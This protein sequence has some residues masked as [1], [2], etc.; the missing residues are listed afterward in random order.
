MTAPM[1]DIADDA[2]I[3]AVR[4]RE[5]G[6]SDWSGLQ[7]WL[8]A[9]ASHLEAYDAVIDADEWL[10]RTWSVSRSEIAASKPAGSVSILREPAPIVER[11]KLLRFALP[12]A[13][14]AALV[15]VATWSV[16]PTGPTP[17]EYVTQ[18]GEH[19]SFALADGSRIEI[20]GASRLTY[21]A[22]KPRMI[23]LESGEAVFKVR[24][25]ATKPFVVQA[26]DARLIDAGTE[27]NV[28]HE[29]GR[30]EV[31]VAEGAVI[32]DGGAAPIRLEPGEWLR[33][34]G[35]GATIETGTTNLGSVGSWR[36]GL[37]QYDDA[38]LA[39]IAQDLSRS[40]GAAVRPSRAVGNLRY[41]GT[42]A[43]D[44]PA[45]DVLTRIG[46]LLGVTFRADGDGW[47]MT[48]RDAAIR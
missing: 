30:L 10:D 16:L 4:V 18:P 19:R 9:D 44:G 35:F 8:E 23:S 3:W 37:L 24:H 15:G 36:K 42:L 25:D 7:T 33:R 39:V 27:F 45:D 12:G 46:P 6:F 13:I 2:A 20:N 21:D 14:A 31:A 34:A 5:P 22:S 29:N 32:Y 47:E 48:P 43:V 41:T 26:G 38:T 28:V 11:R 17:T 40:V 1:R